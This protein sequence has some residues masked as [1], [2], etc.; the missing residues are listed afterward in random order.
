MKFLLQ[1]RF[2][3]LTREASVTVML[4]VE[5]SIAEQQELRMNSPWK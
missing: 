1:A 3:E 5:C 4:N 2:A